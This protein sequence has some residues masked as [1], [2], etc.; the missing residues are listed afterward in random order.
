MLAEVE[1]LSVTHERKHFD[2]DATY[3]GP[4]IAC[5]AVIPYLSVLSKARKVTAGMFS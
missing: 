5:T 4:Q 1:R 2:F 3:F